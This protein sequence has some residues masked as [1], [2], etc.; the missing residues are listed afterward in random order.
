MLNAIIENVKKFREALYHFFP[1]RQDAAMELLDS[2]SSNNNARSVAELS[3]NP[4]HRRTYCSD[5]RVIDEYYK[6]LSEEERL[7]RENKL[8]EDLSTC[9]PQVR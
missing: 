6:G 8:T 5:T 7:E 9:C 4:M 1:S 2:I 3:L